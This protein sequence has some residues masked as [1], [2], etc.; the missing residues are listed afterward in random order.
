MSQAWQILPI[1]ASHNEYD[2]AV[3]ENLT[4]RG[5]PVPIAGPR[6]VVVR[7]RAAALNFRDLLVTADSLNYPVRTTAG[8]V[9]CSDG[10]GQI[11]SVGADSKW[12]VGDEV[13]LMPNESW[14]SGGVEKFKIELALGGGTTRGTLTRHRLVG[15]EWLVRKPENLTFEEAASLPTAGGT[16][17]NALFHNPGLAEEAD[18]MALKGRTVLA[19]GTGGVSCFV[20]QLA[21]AMG[22]TV[23]AT[24]SSDEKLE[25]AKSLGAH[26]LVNYKTTPGWG[27]EVLKRT[28]GVG[29]DL[30]VEVGGAG[31]I[32]QSLRATRFG[33]TVVLL[34][35]LT[36]SKKADLVPAV[37]VSPES[38]WYMSC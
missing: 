7:M 1:A 28:G 11:E 29:A 16:A 38:I 22:A 23:V 33:G 34:G 4:L 31:T 17:I 14:K 37:L 30:V 12:K 26:Y 3:L 18:V 35:V 15:D 8:L 24:S 32:E 20:I 36:E 5:T 10:A 27:D 2:P 25:L 9:P 19:Q 21:S 6:Q 13:I